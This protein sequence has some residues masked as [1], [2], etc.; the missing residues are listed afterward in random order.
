[1]AEERPNTTDGHAGDSASPPAAPL[2]VGASFTMNADGLQAENAPTIIS[3]TPPGKSSIDPNLLSQLVR[4]R[5]LGHFE[6]EEPIGVGGMAAVIKARDMNLDRLVALK[7]LPPEMAADPDH[8]Q[9]FEQEARAAARLDHEN[10]AR[11]YF[12]GADKGLHFI[13]FEFVEGEN[14]RAR[15]DR[16]GTLSVAE[17]V[18][19]VLQVAKGLA[20]AAARGVVHR[21]IKPSNI[22]VGEHGKAKLVD[23]GLARSLDRRTDGGLTH[24]GV[25]LGTFDYISPE[26]A[27][28]PRSADVRSDLYSLGCT[29]YQMLTGR[30]PAPE[31]TAAR[32]LQFHQQE[33]PLDPREFNPDIP[34]EVAAILARMM[35]K[36]PSQRYQQP[37]HLV[38]HLALVADHLSG[39]STQGRRKELP[40]LHSIMPTPPRVRPAL[41][42]GVAALAVT[43]LIGLIGP[44]LGSEPSEP[45]HRVSIGRTPGAEPSARRAGTEPGKATPGGKRETTPQA[46]PSDRVVRTV[47]ELRDLA[48]EERDAVVTVEEGE[49]DLSGA[50]DDGAGLLLTGSRL[51]L[52][53][54]SGTRPVIRFSPPPARRNR[55]ALALRG[56]KLV[57]IGLRIEIETEG[58]ESLL[59]ALSLQGG[60][61]ICRDCEIVQRSLSA[62]AATL[63]V[64][65]LRPPLFPMRIP[66]RLEFQDCVFYGGQRGFEVDDTEQL[67]LERCAFGLF[68]QP[69]HLRGRDAGTGKMR[70]AINDCLFL[71]GSGPVV[72]AETRRQLDLDLTRSVFSRPLVSESGPEAMLCLFGRDQLGRCRLRS[73]D[74]CFHNLS[75]FVV[76]MGEDGT[77]ENLATKL[78]D[79]AKLSEELRD[80]GSVVATESPWQSPDPVQ[81]LAQGARE[82]VIAAFRLKTTLAAVRR[83]APILVLGPRSLLGE[84]LYGTLDSLPSEAIST[85]KPGVK[86]L[87]VDGVGGQPGTYRNLATALSDADFEE[88][89]EIVITLK[90]NGLLPSRPL[91]IGS[92]NVTI[93]AAPGFVPELTFN[94][95]SDPG[96]DGEAALF[97]LRDGT[98]TFEQLRF[99]IQPTLKESARLQSLLAITGTGRCRIKGCLATLMGNDES[100]MALASVADPTGAMMGMGGKAPRAGIPALEVEDCFV[101]GHGDFVTVRVSRPYRL[102]VKNALVVLQGSFLSV[103]GNKRE[104][105]PPPDGATMA[106]DRVTAFVTQPLVLLRASQTHPMHVPLRVSSAITC[107]L[108]T[109]EDSPLLRVD[110]PDSEIE[111]KRRLTWQGRKNFYSSS[112]SLLVWQGI[113]MGEMPHKYD[114]ERWNELWVGED[115]QPHFARSLK[116]AGYPDSGKSVLEIFPA[117]FRVVSTD[118][119]DP[120]LASRGADL[121]KLPL[122]PPPPATPS[123]QN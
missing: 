108:A 55:T 22:I 38:Q 5:K 48:N 30:S 54:K 21:D 37:E 77:H 109:A 73:Q 100:R 86:E 99:R 89:V 119:V 12:C 87:I 97:R 19:Y 32:K 112:G 69:F 34:G 101:R 67:L 42:L 92:R 2:G 113:G 75:A 27:L 3:K 64:R 121:D 83:P 47:H 7:V 49:Y 23:M 63:A 10:I 57:L 80:S 25:T 9:R 65:A 76:R 79:L 120:E 60:Q 58:S 52:V 24:S 41:V 115:E 84:E 44:Y 26:Q 8:L 82:D 11:V 98:L 45:G 56:G 50:D 29:F 53:A 62:D 51:V 104:A 40:L 18:N 35:A 70:L 16:L 1:M 123:E 13:A 15:V 94:P 46:V 20:H 31:G 33:L 118:P 4:G 90:W 78:S 61:L 36:D 66:N 114:R 91:E 43:V 39:D 81:Q 74:N 71:L 28:E 122:P 17:A 68:Q 106:L 6:L 93:R 105:N 14:L 116:F 110:G 102:E 96:A 88:E 85:P 111:L 107:L 95:D 59:A 117:D 103:G 72:W